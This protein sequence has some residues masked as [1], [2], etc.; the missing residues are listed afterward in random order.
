[1]HLVIGDI[2]G[3]YRAFKNIL[4]ESKF[5]P[6]RD[7]LWLTGDLVNRGP[8]SADVVRHVMDLGDSAKVVLGN[9]D[10]HLLAVAA[11]VS[12]PKRKDNSHLLLE[13]ADSGRLIEWLA[14][15]P[16]ALFNRKHN[17]LLVHASIH[18]NWSTDDTLRYAGEIEKILNSDSRIDYLKNMYGSR[19]AN[20]NDNLKGWDR[21][22]VITNLLTRARFCRLDGSL[23]LKYKG[24]PG[25]QAEDLFPWY[26]IPGRKNA[27]QLIVFGHWSAL[28]YSYNNNTL[29]LDSGYLWGGR[30]TALKLKKNKSRII[31]IEHD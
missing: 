17:F 9:H 1:M 23:N 14:S 20:W 25:S 26:D 22:R 12:K 13:N 5:R 21:L 3:C 6:A 10:L 16:L 29:C 7:Q 11:G 4:K 19:P 30:L 15:R 2:H 18:K 27:S 28:G 31:Q 24:P 8:N